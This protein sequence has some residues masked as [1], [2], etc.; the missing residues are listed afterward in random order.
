MPIK[1]IFSECSMNSWLDIAE[2][3]KQEHGWKLCYWIGMQEFKQ[4]TKER[5]PDVIFHSSMDTARG[6]FTHKSI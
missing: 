3:L 5:F 6:K 1:A 4:S 2:H